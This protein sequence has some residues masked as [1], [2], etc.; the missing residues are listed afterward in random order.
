MPPRWWSTTPSGST[1]GPAR[2]VGVAERATARDVGLVVAHRPTAGDPTLAALDALLGRSQPLVALG[3]LD[4]A[5]VREL[6][7][8]ELGTAVD[9]RLVEALHDHTA[10]M[11]ALVRLVLAAWTADGTVRGGRLSAPPAP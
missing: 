5:E 6:A 11:P 1:P 10:G 7:A 9:D 3:P 2:V 8:V 4:E